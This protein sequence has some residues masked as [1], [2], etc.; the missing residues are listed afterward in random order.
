M[1]SFILFMLIFRQDRLQTS[2]FTQ[3]PQSCL[4]SDIPLRDILPDQLIGHL[5]QFLGAF[6][7]A[8][9]P[10]ID[11]RFRHLMLP[12]VTAIIAVVEK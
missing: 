4:F 6:C 1:L 5:I 7:C 10:S 3:Q 2:A 8:A 12:P 9:L 11:L